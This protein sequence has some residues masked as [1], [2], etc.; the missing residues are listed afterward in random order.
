[1]FAL[2]RTDTEHGERE[3]IQDPQHETSFFLLISGKGSPVES[4]YVEHVKFMQ[5]DAPPS[6][7]NGIVIRL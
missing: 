1:M 7:V 4:Q 3:A 5:L 6:V 2:L